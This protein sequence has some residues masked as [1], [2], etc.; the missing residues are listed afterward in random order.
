MSIYLIN[1]HL[2]TSELRWVEESHMC[3]N[4]TPLV[5]DSSWRWWDVWSRWLGH[6]GSPHTPTTSLIIIAPPSA[7]TQRGA[8]TWVKRELGE[9][10]KGR[11][12]R[13]LLGWSQNP[14]GSGCERTYWH[15]DRPTPSALCSGSTLFSR[16]YFLR[17]KF[18][19]LKSPCK[20]SP[21]LN[22]KS[23]K[24]KESFNFNIFLH[25]SCVLSIIFQHPH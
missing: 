19:S 12:L 15:T 9:L 14:V 10:S 22:G 21:L 5:S 13:F 7:P 8:G 6:T 4:F 20:F 16:K 17:S 24:R 3:D 11:V 2:V 25:R 23:T 18:L 1:D